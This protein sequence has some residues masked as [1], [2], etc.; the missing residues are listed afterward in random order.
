MCD[1]TNQIG[2]TNRNEAVTVQCDFQF[3]HKGDHSATVKRCSIC[4]V[5][6]QHD[7]CNS[8]D[9]TVTWPQ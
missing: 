1:A 9:F 7:V 4:E 3:G 6:L 5:G 2:K 8:D